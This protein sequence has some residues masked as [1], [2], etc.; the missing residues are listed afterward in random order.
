MGHPA[1]LEMQLGLLW[2]INERLAGRPGA[3]FP[4]LDPEIITDV[5]EAAPTLLQ[6]NL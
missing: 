2:S 5:L 6:P 4:R 3:N 1:A